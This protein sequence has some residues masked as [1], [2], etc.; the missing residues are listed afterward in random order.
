MG[1]QQLVEMA[2]DT[3]KAAQIRDD[4]CSRS[5]LIGL[6]ALTEIPEEMITAS[7]SLVG[8]TGAASGS[9]GAYCAGL[10]GVGMKY[11][12]PLEDELSNPALMFEGIKKAMEYRDRFLAVNGSILCPAIQEKLF[13]RSYIF[14]D[15]KQEEEFLSLEGHR[16]KCAEIVGHATRIAA[17]MIIAGDEYINL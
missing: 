1:N 2:V 13:G 17:E 11:N 4:V 9:C 7:L 6:S 3:A 8:G 15:P 5:V 16:E 10:L 12:Y 14:T